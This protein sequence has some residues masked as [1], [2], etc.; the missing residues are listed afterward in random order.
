MLLAL[1]IAEKHI[2]ETARAGRETIIDSAIYNGE[3][4]HWER[5]NEVQRKGLF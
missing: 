5:C 2:D 3:N 4:E 1:T